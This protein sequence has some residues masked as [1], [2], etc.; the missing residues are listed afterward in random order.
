MGR[1]SSATRPGG[2]GGGNNQGSRESF[3]PLRK[4]CPNGLLSR[5]EERKKEDGGDRIGFKPKWT[6][7]P[8][9]AKTKAVDQRSRIK[10]PVRL[11]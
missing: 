11:V 1:K 9:A 7:A 2:R 5:I 8:A 3:R 4:T 10:S 6:N